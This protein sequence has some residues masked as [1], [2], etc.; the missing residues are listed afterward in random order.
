MKKQ[1]TLNQLAEF[2]QVASAY[3]SKNGFIE[4]LKYTTKVETKLTSAIKSIFKQYQKAL[5]DIQSDIELININNCL[6]DPNTKEILKDE[7]GNFKYSKEGLINRKKEIKAIF[8]KKIDIHD[9][10][11][12]SFPSNLTEEE[13]EMF[14][15]IVIPLPKK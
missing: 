15:G 5:K 10:I 8:D 11:I 12:D 9:R 13:I 7:K 14:Q 6:D 3:L 2:D 4:D 1:T